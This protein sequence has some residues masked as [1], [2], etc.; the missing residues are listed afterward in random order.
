MIRHIWAYN[1]LNGVFIPVRGADLPH[2]TCLRAVVS[3]MLGA[4]KNGA[5]TTLDFRAKTLSYTARRE[6][7][8]TGNRD[9]F[10]YE[11]EGDSFRHNRKQKEPSPAEKGDRL[12]WM[13]RTAVFQASKVENLRFSPF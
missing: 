10:L 8:V 12:R 9:C 6:L 1:Q 11:K 7:A 13:R 4:T 2:T 3:R 5:D